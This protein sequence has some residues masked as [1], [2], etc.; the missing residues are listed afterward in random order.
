M[1]F[2]ANRFHPILTSSVIYYWTDARQ[3]RVYLFYIIKKQTIAAFLF[4]N[5]STFLESPPLPTLA[6]TKKAIWRNLLSIQ[7][8]AISLFAM[9]SKKLWLVREN[10]AA[11]KLDSNGF[12][13]IKTYSKST[14]ELRNPLE[15]CRK[16][17]THTHKY[18][19][20]DLFL[21]RASKLLGPV[22]QPVNQ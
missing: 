16:Q 20:W 12:Y 5:L 7:S 19:A 10:H 13:R 21:K 9:C 8:E 18:S 17:W 14:I 2:V 22:S 4:Q 11:V 3:H 6:N 15:K 1:W